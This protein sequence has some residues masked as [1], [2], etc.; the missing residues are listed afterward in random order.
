MA[1]MSPAVGT[2]LAGRGDPQLGT[3]HALQARPWAP[4][5]SQFDLLG[6]VDPFL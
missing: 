3:H 1:N 2:F 5:G 4:T 6:S